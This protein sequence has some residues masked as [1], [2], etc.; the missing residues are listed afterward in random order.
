MWLYTLCNTQPHCESHTDTHS[1]V[2][3]LRDCVVTQPQ[4]ERVTQIHMWLHGSCSSYCKNWQ[5]L[6]TDVFQD[7]LHN[8]PRLHFIVSMITDWCTVYTLHSILASICSQPHSPPDVL[9]PVLQDILK[10]RWQ[11]LSLES[12]PIAVTTSPAPSRGLRNVY[13]Y[14]DWPQKC[15]EINCPRCLAV[16]STGWFFNWPPLKFLST[17][18]LI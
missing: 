15:S 18:K 4:S 8:I 7:H 1:L 6:K 2:T 10:G 17:N 12:R 16:H 11:L 3:R 5:L 13:L 14:M 9:L